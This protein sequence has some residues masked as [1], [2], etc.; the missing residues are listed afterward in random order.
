MTGIGQRGEMAGHSFD[1]TRLTKVAQEPP[2]R[3]FLVAEARRRPG[4]H[5]L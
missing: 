5:D 1:K 3:G 2:N 4:E